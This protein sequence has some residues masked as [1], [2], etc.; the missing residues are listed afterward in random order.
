MYTLPIINSLIWGK[1]HLVSWKKSE[2]RH[3]LTSIEI[4]TQLTEIKF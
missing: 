1:H 4:Q 3:M 2:I